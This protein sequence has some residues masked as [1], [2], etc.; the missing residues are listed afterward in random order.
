MPR[1][2]QLSDDLKQT[3]R[4]PLNNTLQFI[5][6]DWINL[7]QF[8]AITYN[9]II[10]CARRCFQDAY[11]CDARCNSA[12]IRLLHLHVHATIRT[13]MA[14]QYRRFSHIAYQISIDWSVVPMQ[15]ARTSKHLCVGI[16]WCRPAEPGPERI[17]PPRQ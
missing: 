11:L 7:A 12:A 10:Y 17:R 3:H 15:P 5:Q 14:D 13:H 6:P 1:C 2:D 16:R 9:A 4:T 8:Y